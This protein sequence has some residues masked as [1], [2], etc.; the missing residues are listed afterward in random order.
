MV[1]PVPARDGEFVLAVSTAGTP[2]GFP[3]LA[4]RSYPFGPYPD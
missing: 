3:V 1:A 2:L 4:G